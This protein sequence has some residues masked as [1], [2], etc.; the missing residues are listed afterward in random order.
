LRCHPLAGAVQYLPGA[1]LLL[2]LLNH[3]P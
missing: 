1:D 2:C 3:H